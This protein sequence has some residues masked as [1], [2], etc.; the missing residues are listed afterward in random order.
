MSGEVKAN[1]SIKRILRWCSLLTFIYVI[2]V[3]VFPYSSTAI[4]SYHISALQYRFAVIMIELP[5]IVVWFF[6]F[7]GYGKLK[8]YAWS[9]KQTEEGKYFDK[10][11]DG[12]TWLAWSLPLSALFGRILSG[13][14]GG[15][16]MGHSA[17][18]IVDNYFAL[19][20]PF[21]AFIII[22]LATRS[23]VGQKNRIS[24][25]TSSGQAIVSIFAVIGVLY[26]YLL[27]KAF[28]LHS[29][30]SSQNHYHLPA[31]LIVITI[32]IPYLYAWLTGLLAACELTI[33]ARKV[34]GVLYKKALMNLIYGLFAVVFSFISSQ[35]SSSV[36]PSHGHLVFDSRLI[37]ITI[38]RIIGGL[39]FILMAVGANQLKRIEEV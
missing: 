8:Q 36:W 34:K 24:L 2:T 35:Y 38:F 26:C 11:A 27:L 14:N 30:S 33:Y 23:I 21:I 13:L 1:S 25:A 5:V 10:L 3:F 22:G 18:T 16:V 28:D 6:A 29:L 31:W 20:L 4:N 39:G 32:M 17:A 15:S 12:M 19:L 37:I 7:W 9:I